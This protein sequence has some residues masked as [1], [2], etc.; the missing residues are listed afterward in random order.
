MRQL[1]S[2]GAAAE[3]LAD[4]IQ[5]LLVFVSSIS[6]PESEETL[7]DRLANLQEADLV[8]LSADMMIPP[9]RFCVLHGLSFRDSRPSGFSSQEEV[10]PSLHNGRE[11]YLAFI[12]KWK[13]SGDLD[14]SFTNAYLGTQKHRN[15]HQ[16]PLYLKQ[17]LARNRSDIPA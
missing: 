14:H 11:A 5:R 15:L 10:R 8:A 4:V 9:S 6:C 2:A 12:A 13:L 3:D 1:S 16:I 17:D 7:R